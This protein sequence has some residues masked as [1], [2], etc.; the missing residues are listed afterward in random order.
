M[1]KLCIRVLISLLTFSSIITLSQPRDQDFNLLVILPSTA[2]SNRGNYDDGI[3]SS[4]ELIDAELARQSLKELCLP[5]ALSVTELRTDCNSAELSLVQL[6]RELT[7]AESKTTVAVTGSFCKIFSSELIGIAGRERLGLVQIALNTFLPVVEQDSQFY[8]MLPSTLTYAEALTQFMTHVGWTRI[9]V[10]FSQTRNNYHFEMSEQ[11]KRTLKDRGFGT[12][13]ILEVDTIEHNLKSAIRLIWISGVKIVHI[14]LPPIE[15]TLLIC[16]AYDYGLQWPEYGWI[17]PGVSLGDILSLNSFGK[18]SKNAVQGIISFQVTNA[19]MSKAEARK[20]YACSEE[21]FPNI[22][23]SL[24][25]NIYASA[26]YDST[27]AIAL[28][29]NQTFPEV[30]KYLAKQS[31][32]SHTHYSKLVAQKR[33]SQKIGQKLTNISFLGKLGDISFNRK[34]KTQTHITIY[35]MI[36]GTQQKLGLYKPRE[37]TSY[38]ENYPNS[39][40]PSDELT[41]VYMFLPVPVEAVLMAVVVACV[42]ITLLNMILYLYYRNEP[43]MKASSVGLSMIIY[44]SSYLMYIG[45]GVNITSSSMYND[46]DMGCLA[47][48]WTIFP[49]GDI[50]LSTLIVKLCRIYHIFSYFGKVGKVCSDKS[51]LIMI[52]LI[53]LGK[54]AI[55]SIWTALDQFRIKDIVTYHT[56]Q[57]KPPFYE[58]IQHCHSHS[59]A[60]WITITLAYTATIG[61]VLAFASFKTRKVHRK[62]F[63]DTKKINAHISTCFIA[64]VIIGSLWWILRMTGNPNISKSLISVLYLLPPLCCQVYLFSPKTMPPLK[65]SLHKHFC[66]KHHKRSRIHEKAQFLQQPDKTQHSQSSLSSMTLK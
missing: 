63:K 8:Q 32:N 65:R 14:L 40:I 20:S 29:L 5:F 51:L 44:L 28:A 24:K 31:N 45:S 60:I 43:E 21:L 37:N 56:V 19:N 66:K 39:N 59:F 18:C 13:M 11:I 22:N 58:V 61:C 33:V 1:D 30:Q 4:E 27:Q 50:I 46:S 10:A 12:T 26:L 57:G 62:D 7:A 55:L 2:D 47:P 3:Q 6:V 23:E 49:G 15:T 17:V 42:L 64:I 52:L 48:I 34:Q 41:R 35:Q 38:F 54:V 53:L 36:D 25:S 16:L 9:A